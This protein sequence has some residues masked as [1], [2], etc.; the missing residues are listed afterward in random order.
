MKS[1][2]R[3]PW[4]L[5]WFLLVAEVLAALAI[6]PI[7]R[8]MLGAMAAKFERPAVPLPILVAIGVVQNL[9]ILG[10]TLWLGLKLSRQVGLRMPLLEGLVEG[11][12]AASKRLTPILTSGLLVGL[13]IGGI[14]LVCLLLLVPRLP[15]LPFVIAAR[16]PIWKRLLACFYGGVYEEL[17]TRLFLLSVVA[18]IVNRTWRKPT[19]Q[20]SN[21]A[22]WFAN[23]FT[24]IV[25]GL[26]HLPSASLFMPITALVVVAA[27]LLNGVAGIAFGYLFRTRGLEAA[28][29]AHF[30]ADFVI[31]VVGASLVRQ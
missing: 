15:N 8:D 4:R 21:A 24:A 16:L 29:I 9:A 10:I 13:V 6:V 11:K 3:Y 27:L 23:I 12:R 1:S 18:W 26:G 25:F 5:F 2:Q 20:L 7:A 14:L 17:F 31:Y 22:F 28:M 30:T 19:P